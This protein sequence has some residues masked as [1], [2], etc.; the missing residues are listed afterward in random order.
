MRMCVTGNGDVTH[1][2]YI[3]SPGMQEASKLSVQGD[4]ELEP[5]QVIQN[6]LWRNNFPES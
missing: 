4:A 6:R 3:S 5:V 2:E 1:R